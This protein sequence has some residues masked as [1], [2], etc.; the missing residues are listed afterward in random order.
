MMFGACI[1]RREICGIHKIALC[2]GLSFSILSC[3]TPS[4]ESQACTDARPAVR[5]FYSFHIGNDMALSSETLNRRERFLSTL[6]YSSLVDQP[7]GIDPFT[8][9]TNDVPRAFRV[10]A[11]KE[12]GK[13]RVN[14]QIL[15]FWR[16]DTD[17]AQRSIDVELIEANGRW[18]I[19]KITF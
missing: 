9:G 18:L 13:S 10:G 14:F 8:T 6:L 12:A 15:L 3:S 16:D 17:T 7:E 11:C 19:D 2:L 5:E 1:S 4:L